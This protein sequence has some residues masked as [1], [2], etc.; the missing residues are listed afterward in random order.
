MGLFRDCREAGGGGF[1]GPFFLCTLRSIILTIIVHRGDQKSKKQVRSTPS[2]N[3]SIA[4]CC[5]ASMDT[6][7]VECADTGRGDWSEGWLGGAS[8]LARDNG[9][10]IEQQSLR[11]S[12]SC[13]SWRWR[14]ARIDVASV[15]IRK[16]KENAGGFGTGEDVGRRGASERAPQRRCS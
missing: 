6:R 2:D 7:V 15:V 9:R 12:R 8:S 10:G 4:I 1:R 5:T 13:E 14:R 11:S 16:K 3:T